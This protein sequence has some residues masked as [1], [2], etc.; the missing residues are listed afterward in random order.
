MQ[1]STYSLH[2]LLGYFLKL[3]SAGFGGPA[4]LVSY[5]HRD[6]VDQRKW[7]SEEEFQEGLSLAQLAPG[8][9]AAQ[10]AIYLSWAFFISGQ[11]AFPG[12][13][14]YFMELDLRS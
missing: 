6:L 5:M 2:Q 13:N 4:A 9:L 14:P 12:F 8:P 3:G 1:N 7:I 10:L 11:A